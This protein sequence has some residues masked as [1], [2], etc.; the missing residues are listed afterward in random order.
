MNQ[1]HS[2][3]AEDRRFPQSSVQSADCNSYTAPS[4]FPPSMAPL[5]TMKVGASLLA[6][7]SMTVITAFQPAAPVINRRHPIRWI[8]SKD[9][10]VSSRE[11]KMYAPPRPAPKVLNKAPPSPADSS[12]KGNLALIEDT[13][14]N[15]RPCGL[16]SPSLS[17][18]TNP[19]PDA[20]L[21]VLRLHR[22]TS[23]PRARPRWTFP[24]RTVDHHFRPSAER[25]RPVHPLH[26]AHRHR[27]VR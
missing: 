12:K 23:H 19:D 9:V 27:Q 16:L 5:T 15:S 13:V 11:K 8:A 26:G 1:G 3:E 17:L 2:F 24:P 7:A 4:V 25:V 18:A 14:S 6:C 10:S 20:P 22:S 21:F